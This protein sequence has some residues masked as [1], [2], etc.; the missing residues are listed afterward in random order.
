[1]EKLHKPQKKLYLL[2]SNWLWP[3]LQ[4]LNLC[5][6]N[7]QAFWSD[8]KSQEGSGL[9]QEAALL[10]LAVK[11]MLMQHANTFSRSLKCSSTIVLYTSMSS[12]KTY[13]SLSSMSM[14]RLFIICMNISSSIH[15]T[16]WHYD[17]FT[18]SLPGQKHCFQYI[19]FCYIILP[20][21]TAKIQ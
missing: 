3:F 5:I 15:Q 20:I 21:T 7:V 1:M 13:Y 18:Q 12:R 14:N 9:L 17:P 8:V 16:H 2:Y 11:Y 4:A 6:T 10:Q 19:F